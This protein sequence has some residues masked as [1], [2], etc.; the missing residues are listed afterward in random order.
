MSKE[1]LEAFR[2][3]E[4]DKGIKKED[5]IEAINKARP[6]YV[7]KTENFSAEFLFEQRLTGFDDSKKRRE[8]LSDRLNLGN[9]N[10]KT[11]LKRLNNFN[12]DK[13]EVLKILEE[14]SEGQNI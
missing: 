9:P 7:S 13:N 3:L 5:I 11:L 4:E 14:Y 6:T 2:I 8:Y 12:I 1:M 10:A